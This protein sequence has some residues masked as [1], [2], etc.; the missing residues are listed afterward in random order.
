MYI[1]SFKFII[2]IFNFF[3]FYFNNLIYNMFIFFVFLHN[4]FFINSLKRIFFV[5]SFCV[6]FIFRFLNYYIDECRIHLFLF[7]NP[8]YLCTTHFVKMVASKRK[9]NEISDENFRRIQIFAQIPIRWRKRK[10]KFL[11]N[12]FVLIQLDITLV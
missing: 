3:L 12:R 10:Q 8:Q 11:K 9:F 5:H 7:W 2:S 4:F 1:T 6:I